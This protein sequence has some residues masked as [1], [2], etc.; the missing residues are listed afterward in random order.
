[1]G[2][3]IYGASTLGKREEMKVF[4]ETLGAWEKRG[5]LS[6]FKRKFRR[7]TLILWEFTKPKVLSLQALF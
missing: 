4:F 6:V 1:L 3:K 7:K 5:E 2:E